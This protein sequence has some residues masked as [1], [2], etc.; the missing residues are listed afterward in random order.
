VYELPALALRFLQPEI[1]TLFA[2]KVSLPAT[3]ATAE[4]DLAWRKY[5]VPA[6]I[7]TVEVV[8]PNAKVMVV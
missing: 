2:L 4:I 7:V 6:A 8:E 1:T 3:E 5:K